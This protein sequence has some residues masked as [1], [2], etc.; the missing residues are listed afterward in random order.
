[1]NGEHDDT[2]A[3]DAGDNAV[4]GP[5]NSNQISTSFFPPPPQIYKKFTKRNLRYLEVLNSHKFANNEASWE[6]LTPSQRLERQA[7]ILRQHASASKQAS[8][9]EGGDVEMAPVGEDA[10]ESSQLD[11]PDFD[12]KK[13]LEP[14]NVDWIE[15]DGGYTV[16]GQ[17]WPIPTSHQLW[18][19]SASRS[20]P[21][22][23]HGSQRA[24]ADIAANAA[25][26]LS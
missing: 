22:R 26:N 7:A 13:E 2:G 19:S 5:S 8:E 16:F 17:L 10:A 18:N 11:L 3:Q 6:Q 25:T 9:V 4:A 21:S 14:P 15:E 20:L 24:L 1:M 23:R 12:L